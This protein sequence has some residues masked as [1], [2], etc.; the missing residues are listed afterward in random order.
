MIQAMYW[1]G[2]LPTWKRATANDFKTLKL[3]RIYSKDKKCEKSYKL[4]SVIVLVML[5]SLFWNYFI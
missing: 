1:D 2:S 3:Y 4:F 5:I